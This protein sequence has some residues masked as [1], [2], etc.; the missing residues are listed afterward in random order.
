MFIIPAAILMMVGA[1]FFVALIFFGYD[2]GTDTKKEMRRQM[3]KRI[4]IVWSLSLLC[5]YLHFSFNPVPY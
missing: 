5:Y 3:W 2:Y 1:Y 4:A